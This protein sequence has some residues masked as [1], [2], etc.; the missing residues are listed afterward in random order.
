MSMTLSGESE[1]QMSELALNFELITGNRIRWR[2]APAG[3]AAILNLALQ[4]GKPELVE[5]ANRVID[6]M[7]GAI[8][9]ELSNRGLA[10]PGNSVYR[11]ARVQELDLEHQPEKKTRELTYRGAKYLSQVEQEEGIPTRPK[12]RRVYRGQVIED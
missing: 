11:G 12:S 7:S 6:G 10:L 1:L 4:S 8:L 2:N 3:M 9:N 5:L